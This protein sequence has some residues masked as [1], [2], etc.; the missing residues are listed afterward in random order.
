MPNRW[1]ILTLLFCVRVTMAFQYQAVATLSP[2]VM[3][4]FGVGLADIGLLIGLYLSPGIIIAFPG[5]AIGRRFGDKETVSLGML[6]MLAGGLLV[7]LVPI[8]EAQI[9]G[10][11]LAGVGGVVLNV[12]MSKMVTDWFAG[13]KLATAMGIFINSWP[14]GIAG[15]LLVLPFVAE[16]F[17]LVATMSLI[18]ALVGV[19]LVS[20]VKL[21]RS[22]VISVAATKNRS[23]RLDRSAMICVVLA[24]AI[25]GLY[26]SALGMIFGFGPAMLVERGWSA[27]AASSTTSI[28]LWIVAISVPLG[29]F[30]ADRLQRRD[31]VLAV[32]LLSFA[33]LILTTPG[34]EHIVLMFIALGAVGGLAAGPIMSLPAE[35]LRPDNRA[36]G[37]GLFFTLYY[38]AIFVAPV[39]AGN[40]SEAAGAADV[41]FTFGGG[42]LIA[43]FLL[44]GLF[45]VFARSA[46][47]ALAL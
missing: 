47:A 24:A 18:S 21:Y 15:A 25:W 27:S 38:L 8:W 45:R 4:E 2:F 3:Q 40:L 13:E 1:S 7:A 14:V 31:L 30:I 6:L 41:A 32:G 19:G 37:M 39:I 5:T 26:N 29:G 9:A 28:V 44:L 36:Y 46:S 23:S 42:A 16:A 34:T 22:P 12:L 43:S 10:R 35:V 17:G 11:L 20:L 33:V